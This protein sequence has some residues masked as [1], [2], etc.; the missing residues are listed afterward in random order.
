MN[1][2]VCVC[3]GWIHA[4]IR[5]HVAYTWYLCVYTHVRKLFLVALSELKPV[6]VALCLFFLP[7]FPYGS[8]HVDVRWCGCFGLPRALS[9]VSA[10]LKTKLEIVWLAVC[11]CSCA[12]K[13]WNGFCNPCLVHSEFILDHLRARVWSCAAMTAWFSQ[14]IPGCIQTFY[15]KNDVYE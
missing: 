5:T 4:C 15:T 7:E 6:C 12:T 8:V 3:I 11:A 14:H 10:R 2:H 9:T 13:L 1:V